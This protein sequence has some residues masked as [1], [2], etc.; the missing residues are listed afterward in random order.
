MEDTFYSYSSCTNKMYLLILK[1][2][3]KRISS[4]IRMQLALTLAMLWYPLH[5]SRRDLDHDFYLN[6]LC[7]LLIKPTHASSL[8]NFK[9]PWSV[10]VM[11]A[12]M[13]ELEL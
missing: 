5:V 7:H 6:T 3:K 11:K 8:I 10:H 9:S 13:E 1:I 2:S 12:H 4:K